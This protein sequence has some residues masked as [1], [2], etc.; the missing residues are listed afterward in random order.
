MPL[1]KLTPRTSIITIGE[2]LLR[3]SVPAGQ[4]LRDLPVLATHP[5]GA[6]ANVAR[7]LA[8]LGHQT[9]FISRLP[10]QPLARGIADEL[11]RDGVD[12]SALLWQ[13]TGRLGT[14][15]VQ[16]GSPPRATKV[17]YDRAD[18]C[19]THLSPDDLKAACFV[20]ASLLHVSGIT[21]G[22]SP[23]ALATVERAVELTH[24]TGGTVSFDV[25]HR[26][27]VWSAATAAEVLRP[28]L[29]KTDVLFCS[30]RDAAKL[31]SINGSGS[32]VLHDLA[33]VTNAAHIVSSNGA[34]GTWAWQ[35]GRVSHCPAEPVTI[36]D[37][38]GAGDALAAGY[39][40]RL[41][42]DD[43]ATALRAGSIMAALALTCAGDCPTIDALE[44]FCTINSDTFS[45]APNR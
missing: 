40:H 6:E 7:N 9:H 44:L 28:L 22:L 12:I 39:L 35:H 23:N 3:L 19:A 21:C 2:V 45:S 31:W 29:A 14:F 15:F 25:N 43:T 1:S 5:A 32:Q 30:H 10:D 37:R 27:K 41:L 16:Q 4:T 38:L 18:S 8:Q 24:K 34:A 20:D 36:V 13:P 26:D 11:R 17:I 42:H 33:D